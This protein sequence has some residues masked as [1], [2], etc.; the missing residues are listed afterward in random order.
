MTERRNRLNVWSGDG[1]PVSGGERSVHVSKLRMLIEYHGL[2]WHVTAQY[3]Y[4]HPDPGRRP[5]LWIDPDEL[6]QGLLKT[7]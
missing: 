4:S 5:P 7:P 1:T 2:T 3:F 6:G